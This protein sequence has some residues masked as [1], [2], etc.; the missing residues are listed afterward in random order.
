MQRER[1]LE[2]AWLY[3]ASAHREANRAGENYWDLYMQELCAQLGLTAAPLQCTSAQA[4]AQA[5]QHCSCLFVGAQTPVLKPELQH[6][7]CH[8][9]EAGGLL[10]GFRTEGLDELFGV[11]EVGPKRRAES[12]FVPSAYLRLAHDPLAAGLQPDLH[13]EHPLLVFG[14]VRLV[15]AAGARELATLLDRDGRSALGVGVSL[16]RSGEGWAA[17]WAFSLPQT[18]WVLHQGRP[19]DRD[20]DGD[21]YYRTGDL[22]VI[23][24]HE[25]E[26]PYAD[27]LV[28][29][30]ERLVAL[31]PHPRLYT[32]PPAGGQVPRA[33]IYWA[34]DDEFSA[35]D[36]LKASQF[37]RS[38]E[39]PYH[40]NV[41][42]KH[43]EFAIS[44]EEVEAILANGHDVSLHYN[45]VPSDGF[46]SAYEFGPEDVHQQAQ[47]FRHR[48]G[49][50]PY[51][52][53]NHW[54]R[55][56]GWAEPARWMAAEGGKGDGS[57]VHARMPPL[58]PCDIFGFPFGT[59]FPFRF[60][61]DWKHGNET[62]PFVEKPLTGYEM[63]YSAG[64]ANF[65]QLYRLLDLTCRRHLVTSMFFHSNRI[66]RI[67]Y[68]REAIAAVKGYFEERGVP[69]KHLSLNGLVRW[70]F[71]RLSSR[72]DAASLTQSGLCFTVRTP[73]PEGA[74]VVVPLQPGQGAAARCDG[75]PL[76]CERWQE[77]PGRS[78]FIPIP[79]GEH[80]VQVE[81][82][83]EQ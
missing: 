50:A 20:Y 64:G 8:W 15:A 21:G 53:V 83:E 9:V 2:A 26:I 48:F 59:S 33:L 32:M 55:W 27:H 66:A 57:F 31:L 60:Y 68:C 30:L 58:D 6:V 4:L 29:L 40:V 76:E 41:M 46:P 23:G 14:P 73:H 3:D 36:Q 69:V 49:F 12:P 38:L 70:W 47:A 67:P 77:G 37:M 54:L 1:T 25:I 71:D 18:A 74:I 75:K 10:I 81:W 22:F 63:G 44:P 79:H 17:Y 65:T 62:L 56:V 45:F 42:Y 13:P 80:L 16:R 28:W 51:A 7:L 34:G 78:L 82:R 35:G 43:G 24:E 11:R 61:D 52:S 72:I 39:L 5:L 19:I